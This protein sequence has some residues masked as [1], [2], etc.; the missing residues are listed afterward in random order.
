MNP[1]KPSLRYFIFELLKS[2][3]GLG[4]EEIFTMAKDAFPNV[5]PIWLRAKVSQYRSK[6]KKRDNDR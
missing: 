1:K 6:F 5:S 3:P 4:N 2:F